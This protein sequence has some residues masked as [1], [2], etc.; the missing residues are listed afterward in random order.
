MPPARFMWRTARVRKI[1]PSGNV[2]T[3]VG[4]PTTLAAT[5]VAAGGG[6][7]VAA[8]DGNI[9]AA[10]GGNVVTSP[11]IE[12]A[13]SAIKQTKQSNGPFR[14]ADQPFQ[15][16]FTG[17]MTINGDYDQFNGTLAIAIAG[18][19]IL[20]N[21]AQQYDQLVVSGTANLLGGTI[22]FGLFN[23]DDQTNQD[24]VFQPPDGATFDVV[25]A[26]NI[27]V[28][29]VSFIGPIWGD[30]QFFTGSVVTRDDG[31]QAVRLTAIHVPPRVGLMNAGSN[32]ELFYA[33]NYTGYNVE[34]SPDLVNWSTFSTGTNI[35]VLNPTDAS[36][37]FRLSKP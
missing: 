36:Q 35:V 37:F 18:T 5:I 33:T 27:V 8:G 9:V 23:P 19:N 12:A 3:W 16:S 22:A 30:G 31:L 14:P 13:L 26:S 10:G 21:G 4:V 32:M 6:N 7:I 11:A 24:N 1:S 25:V 17:Q 28:N 34:S 15:P 20:S 2:T 29:T